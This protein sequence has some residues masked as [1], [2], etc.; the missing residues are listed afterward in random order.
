MRYALVLLLVLSCFGLK[1]QKIVDTEAKAILEKISKKI[2][3]K[4]QLNADFTFTLAYPEI[5][6]KEEQGKLLQNERGYFV[7]IGDN[8][9]I[10]TG[11]GFYFIDKIDKRVQINDALGDDATDLY[12]PISLMAKY[13]SGEF[14]YAI[15]GEEKV[16]GNRCFMIEFKPVDRYSDLSKIR[17]AIDAN[18]ELPVYVKVFNKDASRIHIG[19]SD[20]ILLDEVRDEIGFN[21]GDYAGF[22]IEDLRID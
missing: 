17:I 14:E 13:D 1:A 22:E 18:K 10:S 19:I 7:S 4:K 16:N 21:K 3:S 12:N 5:D 15:V 6:P 9:V 11:N 8:D 2:E 20:F